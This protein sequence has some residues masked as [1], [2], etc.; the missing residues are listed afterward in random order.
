[1]RKKMLRWVLV[2]AFS[3]VATFGALSGLSGTESGNRADSTWPPLSARSVV[4]GD[5]VAGPS[6]GPFDSTWD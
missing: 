6:V 1:M 2:A 3:A 4:A 5:S